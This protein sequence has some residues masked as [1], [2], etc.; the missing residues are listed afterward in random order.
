MDDSIRANI[1]FG[2]PEE[3]IDD[4]RVREVLEEAQ[5]LTLS[6]SCRKAAIR[7]WE[8]GVSACREGSVRESAL[9]EPS[10][11]IRSC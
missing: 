7:S 4:G 5:L 11:T 10:T 1:A 2:I 8:S 3:E 9:P 6:G